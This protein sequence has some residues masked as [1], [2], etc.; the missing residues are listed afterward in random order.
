MLIGETGG[1]NLS[2]YAAEKTE[3]P[4]VLTEETAGAEEDASV[5]AEPMA[6]TLGFCDPEKASSEEEWTAPED[7]AAADEILTDGTAVSKLDVYIDGV[8]TNALLRSEGRFFRDHGCE[9]G[10]NHPFGEENG[11]HRSSGHHC[12]HRQGDP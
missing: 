3:Q 2:V 9:Q 6:E 11:I 4:V 7:E 10:K 5:L 8:Q 1:M 12:R